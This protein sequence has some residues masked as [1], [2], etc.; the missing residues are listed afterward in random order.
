MEIKDVRPAPVKVAQFK[1]FSTEGKTLNIIQSVAIMIRHVKIT[2]N[3]LSDRDNGQ[4]IEKIEI[5]I[6][7]MTENLML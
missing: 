4:E 3:R 7:K 2:I 1:T 6:T 5:V